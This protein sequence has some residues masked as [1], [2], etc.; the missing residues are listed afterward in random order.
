LTAE[1][2]GMVGSPLLAVALERAYG[3]KSIIVV[4][5]RL[6]PAA[7]SL[8]RCAGLQPTEDLEQWRSRPHQVLIRDFTEVE[9]A[10]PAEAERLLGEVAPS[11]VISIERPGR[12]HRG[13]YHLASGVCT[14]ED[15]A[16]VDH[17]FELARANGIFTL[18]IGDV[19]NELGMGAVAD[20]VRK[21]IPF[22]AKCA[23]PCE[24][25]IAA[26]IAAEATLVASLS[27]WAT[28]GLIA[29]LEFLSKKPRI[30]HSADL[31]RQML[32]NAVSVGLTDGSGYATPTIHNISEDVHALVV[33]MLHWIIEQPVRTLDHFQTMFD[34]VAKLRGTSA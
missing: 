21:T 4:E 14:S 30:L 25:G 20:A 24:G 33:E 22:G 31:E 3:V 1:N 19:G 12:N 16:R 26:S 7:V 5:R 29:A 28:Y 17:V 27:D 18:G 23:C 32:R 6:V 8:S 9:N 34:Q 11:A 13:V 2:E 10:A 15:V